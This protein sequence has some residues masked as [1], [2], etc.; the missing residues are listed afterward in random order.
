MFK[1]VIEA[2]LS[3]KAVVFQVGDFDF[4]TAT[5]RLTYPYLARDDSSLAVRS[6]SKRPKICA[7]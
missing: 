2:S 5:R 4:D 3:R 1:D 7:S 6:N